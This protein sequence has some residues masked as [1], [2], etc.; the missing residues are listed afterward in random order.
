MRSAPTKP[1]RHRPLHAGD[2]SL[3]RC[4]IGSPG[5][6]KKARP[7]GDR[8]W[9]GK[10]T[11]ASPPLRVN[12]RRAPLQSHSGHPNCSRYVPTGPKPHPVRR[13]HPAAESARPVRRGPPHQIS[14]GQLSCRS[15]ANPFTAQEKAPRS[16][17]RQPQRLAPWRAQHR[18]QGIQPRPARP[19]G[20]PGAQTRPLRRPRRSVE[21][22]RPEPRGPRRPN[23]GA[24]AHRRRLG[25]AMGWS[26]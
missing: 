6:R 22:R 14:D 17:P 3:V 9:G 10:S 7:G 5:S 23:R 16:A 20:S 21:T 15:A 8:R 19:D 11:S 26:R 1:N 12:L 18:L 2:P 24:A 25:S 4:Q 13:P